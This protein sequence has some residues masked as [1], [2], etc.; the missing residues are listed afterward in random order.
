MPRE[1][2]IQ[3]P[4]DIWAALSARSQSSGQS[5]GSLVK[6]ALAEALDIAHR[7]MFQVSTSS[8]VVHGVYEGCVSIAELRRHGDLG[9]GTFDELD[10]EMIV[11]DGRCY[12]A[13]A[14]GSVRE[15]ADDVLTPFATVVAFVPHATHRLSDVASW[16]DL[17][18]QLD[19]LRTSD[20]DILA[21][22]M[23]GDI[24]SMVA[25]APCRH[26]SG[27]DIVTATADQAVFTFTA[28]SGTLLGFWSPEYAEQ[29][30]I[31]GYHLHFLSDD[32]RS[33]GH[34]L[35]LAA[36]RLD[37]E[38]QVVSDIHVVL[39]DTE[40]FLR[41]DLGGSVAEALDVAEHER[42]DR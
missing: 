42:S 13:R 5:V 41:T 6:A 23:T 16:A 15:V 29:L 4:D 18:R 20:N 19:G 24:T 33:G 25:R 31:A 37:V 10:G 21:Y 17:A 11:L 8:A 2:R 36:S 3:L 12:Q 26:A 9:L 32:R 14:D 39:P 35:D 22:R 30:A 34:V 40:G 1:L 28:P 27:T 38:V 7:S